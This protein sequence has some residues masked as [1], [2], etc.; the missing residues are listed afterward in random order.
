M[1]QP[2]RPP[3]RRVAIALSILAATIALCACIGQML[4]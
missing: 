3:A 1:T 2:P 4:R